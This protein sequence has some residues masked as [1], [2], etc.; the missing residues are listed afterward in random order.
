M[1]RSASRLRGIGSLRNGVRFGFNNSVNSISDVLENDQYY[2]VFHVDSIIKPGFTAFK[3]VRSR[4]E[5]KIKKEKQKIIS[6]DMIDEIVIDLNANDQSLQDLMEKNKRYD[7][8]EDETKTIG[9]G[10]TSINRSNFVTG[11]LLNAKKDDLIGPVETSRGWALIHVSGISEFDSTEFNV[12]RDALKNEILTR[13]RNQNMQSWFD[14][15]KDN[16]EI[17]DNRNYFY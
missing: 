5:S 4:L 16:A 3:T 14:N 13:K 2:A 9:Q 6:R 8:I 12:Q 1:D 10:F 7:N 11:A 15:L 17:V